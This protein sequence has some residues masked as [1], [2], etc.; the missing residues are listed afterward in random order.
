[1]A[2]IIRRENREMGRPRTPEW[3]PFRLMDTLLRWDPFAETSPSFLPRLETFLPRFDVK[4]TRDG[5]FIHAD[6]PGVKEDDLNVSLTG[7]VLTISGQRNVE[8]KQEDERYFAMERSYGDFTRSF[9]LP[10]GADPDTIKADLK[11]GVLSI[12]LKKKPDVQAKKI[13]IGKGGEVT[14]EPLTMENE[15]E[16]TPKTSAKK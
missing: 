3:D 15:T 9:S 4:E 2:N 11:E 8:Q 7:N 5:Y 6:I 12:E 16:K 1:M 10:E 14:G 13:A